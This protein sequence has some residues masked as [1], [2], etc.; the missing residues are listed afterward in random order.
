[1]NKRFEYIDILKGFAILC[2]TFLHFEAGVLPSWLNVWIGSFMISAFYFASG[3]MMGLKD[4]T[5]T[6]KELV[7]KRWRSLGV[8]YLWF[9]GLILLFDVILWGC[10][11]YDGY[12]VARE[13]Y[14][15][16]TLRGIGTLW[17]LPSLF[18][19]EVVFVW[20]R[21]KKSFL[22]IGVSALVTL[23]YLY[24]Y[25]QWSGEYRNLSSLNQIIDAPL[26]TIRNMMVAWPVV[27]AGFVVARYFKRNMVGWSSWLI[28]LL[29]VVVCGVSLYFASFS[30]LNLGVAAYFLPSVLGPLGWMLVAKMLE[31]GRV[32]QFFSYW[33]R[34]SLVLMATHYSI[35]LV[36]C[37]IV[38]EYY[39]GC[40]EFIGWRTIVYFVV[41][42]ILTYPLVWF[43][44]NK[45]RFM[46]GRNFV[47]H[48]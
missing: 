14:K 10:G 23:V 44:N 8:P 39:F 4:E 25:Y 33:G 31:R 19:G 35:L 22:L 36:L 37:K 26:Y 5:I 29:G 32:M 47:S 27:G 41:T 6:V 30:K 9:T 13:V 42:V 28:G 34:N 15:T 3:W 24:L 45:A 1:M 11:Y 21:N 46:L 16:V 7:R 38:D 2:I 43:F 17:F 40:T 18:F 12:F 20:L 48:R